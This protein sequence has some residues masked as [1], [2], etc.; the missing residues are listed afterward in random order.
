M[1][2]DTAVIDPEICIGCGECL[3]V[4]QF[5]AVK[6]A[7]DEDTANLQKK[8]AEY[9][10]AILEEK[11][12]KAAFFN[13]LT[14]ITKHCDCMDKPFEPDMSDI[15]IV[16]SRDPVAVEKATVDLINEHTGKDYFKNIWP[17]ID[18]TV[19]LEHAHKIG[20]GNLDYDLENVTSDKLARSVS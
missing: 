4:C 16:V 17:K 20:L 6:I 18:Y 14:H 19:Q 10:L 11:K 1:A 13:F 7:W 15:G 3:A 12:Q 2:S 5:D 9:C 8:V